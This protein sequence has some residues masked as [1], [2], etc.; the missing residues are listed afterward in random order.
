MEAC[1]LQ[2]NSPARGDSSQQPG[3]FPFPTHYRQ[4]EYKLCHKIYTPIFTQ[5]AKEKIFS[6]LKNVAPQ[7]GIRIWRDAGGFVRY[8]AL[9]LDAAVD[10]N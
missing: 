6:P 8:M 7:A 9:L 4:N 5:Y 10:R 2:C 1:I 3:P